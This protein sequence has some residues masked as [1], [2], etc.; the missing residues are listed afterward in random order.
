MDPKSATVEGIS[1]RQIDV[2][3]RWVEWGEGLPLVLI[4]GMPTSPLLW[5]EV[6]PRLAG[7]RCLAW[8]M[9]GYGASIVEGC[10]R[11]ISV[12]AQADYLALWL[13]HL[14]ISRAVLA[15]HCAGGAVAQVAAVR[16]PGLCAGLFLTNALAYNSWPPA[17]VKPLQALDRV[18]Q[19]LPDPLFKQI[20]RAWLRH[21][22]DNSAQAGAA[23]ETHWPHYARNGAAALLRQIKAFDVR[24]TLA[25][26]DLL[27]HLNL[28]ARLVWGTADCFQPIEVGERLARDLKAPLRRIEG[29]RHFTPEDHPK[30]VAE[31]IN[32]L[33]EEVRNARRPPVISR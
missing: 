1:V 12:S 16:Y 6:I 26:A 21:G 24:D 10:E 14:G 15:G 17:F 9:V 31:E 18:V 29:A 20:F 28:P 25:A 11:D 3:M 4:H 32:L 27:P 22:H 30:T 23:L 8:E 13:K 33:L 2:P 5:R 19:R 7:A